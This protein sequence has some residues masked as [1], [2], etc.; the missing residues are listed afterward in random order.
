[1]SVLN[2]KESAGG[3]A[4]H[5]REGKG[6]VRIFSVETNAW[7]SEVIAREAASIPQKGAKHPDDPNLKVERNSAVRVGRSWLFDVTVEYRTGDARLGGSEAIHPLKRP[8]DI[9]WG[10]TSVMM[11]IDYAVDGVNT[12]KTIRIL[13][14]AGIAVQETETVYRGGIPY[15]IRR[16]KCP[17]V[18]TANSVPNPKPMNEVS[19]PLMTITR[20]VKDYDSKILLP[21]WN[22]LNKSTF[23]GFPKG[24]V[25]LRSIIGDPRE[26]EVDGKSYEYFALIHNLLVRE[27]GWAWRMKNEGRVAYNE[28][29]GGWIV[30]NDVKTGIPY[31]EPMMLDKK[32]AIADPGAK[33]I[34]LYYDFYESKS[35]ARLKIG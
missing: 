35:W 22:T 28:E 19:V 18:N 13:K 4:W 17:V 2:V 9:S 32:G 6:A 21:Y 24:T 5:D 27:E 14:G 30:L 10:E 33:P 11:P 20:N 1:M 26:E 29:I 34:W 3:R 23:R 25:M 7:D 12:R 8:V 15:K 16:V 31:G